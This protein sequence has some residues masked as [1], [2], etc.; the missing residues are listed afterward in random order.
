MMGLD[1][2]VGQITEKPHL[3]NLPLLLKTH[4]GNIK[5]FGVLTGN[6]RPINGNLLCMLLMDM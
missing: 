6:S 3:Y 5:D 4:Q 1:S 2:E